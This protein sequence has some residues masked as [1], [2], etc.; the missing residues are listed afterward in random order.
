MIVSHL[1]NALLRSAWFIDFRTVDAYRTVLEQLLSGNA[2]DGEDVLSERKPFS[3]Q[4][5]GG[6]RSFDSGDMPERLPEETVAVIPL[7]GTMLK[8]GTYCSYGTTEVA[9]CIQEAA[10]LE[11][12]CGIVLDVDSGGGCVDAIAPVVSAVREA[13]AQGV[14]VVA[15]CDLCASAAYYVASQCD[16]VMAANAIS[17]EFGSIGV[18]MSFKDYTKYYEDIGI[19][20][21]TVY[22]DLSGYKNAPFEA[23]RK[24][25]YSLIRQEELNPLALVFQEAVKKKRCWLD[26][27]V[28]GLLNGRMFFAQ[29][30][31]ANG[32]CDSVGGLGDAVGKAMELSRKNTVD[33]YMECKKKKKK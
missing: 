27:S 28:K 19:K 22:S 10:A 5:V 32:L 9:S 2:T 1:L 25:D 11:N 29:D 4:L 23:A 7:H 21:H 24:G 16:H 12:V 31:V 8:Y 14:P 20:E 15:H 26:L 30:A 6:G 13:A 33:T 3:Y 18:M 17:S